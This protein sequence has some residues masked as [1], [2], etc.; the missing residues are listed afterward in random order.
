MQ[1]DE[2]RRTWS[3]HSR[4]FHDSHV[5]SSHQERWTSPK[6]FQE[7]MDAFHGR[8]QQEQ[9][10]IRLEQRQEKLRQLFFQETELYE[11]ELRELSSD[12][13]TSMKE[14][15]EGLKSQREQERK[16][17]S[18]E[19]L[20]EH[21]RLNCRELRELQSKEME[22]AMH[23][24]WE[25][26]VR[27]KEEVLEAAR[28]EKALYE[29]RLEAE[30]LAALQLEQEM[31]V[32]QKLQGRIHS[33]VLQKQIEE[34][35]AR[36]EEA[37]LWEHRQAQLFK[38]QAAL[39]EAREERRKLEAEQ[40]RV[41]L[42]R[43]L[44]RQYKAQLRRKSQQI[45]ESL[46][47]DLKILED[48]AE[49]EREQQ[50]LQTARRMKARDDME[51]MRKLVEQQLKLEKEKEA[52]MDVL[53]QEEAARMW[54][55]REA[56]WRRETSARQKLMNEVLQER[57]QQ[58][59]DRLDVAKSKQL[60]TIQLREELLREMEIFSKMEAESKTR[61]E[62]RE[63]ER[64]EELQAQ[65]TE[66][67]EGQR[68]AQLRHE[69]ELEEQRLAEEEHRLFLKREQ[70]QILAKGYKPQFVKQRHVWN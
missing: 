7:S 17:V 41:E 1:E 34:L 59:E 19:K 10:K 52:E 44:K 48:L 66:R 29:E 20:H 31:A 65:I 39:E 68:E 58:I 62:Q 11:A 6:L 33:E 56:E 28:R 63:R 16:K 13:W 22:Q 46:E 5:R 42:S 25:E 35:R 18:E 12:K 2:T 43:V 38:E 8:T 49:K 57:E 21:K 24:D 14:R 61:R 3:E 67:R 55:K 53:Y 40:Q 4:Y 23:R 54:E 47:L 30:R 51:E 15:A 32:K 69:R 60:E 36:E 50:E 26:Q 64:Q 70:E 9:K 45:Q 27:H 37:A